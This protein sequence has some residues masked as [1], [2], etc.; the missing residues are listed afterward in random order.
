MRAPYRRDIRQQTD[1]WRLLAG[2]SSLTISRMSTDHL[3]SFCL[4][5]IWMFTILRTAEFE[6]RKLCCATGFPIG[7]A[8]TLVNTSGGYGMI[9]KSLCW[10][11]AEAAGQRS[12]R[13][14]KT[15]PAPGPAMGEYGTQNLSSDQL[16]RTSL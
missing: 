10:P 14:M 8:I 13:R 12:G 5:N 3:S 2:A 11:R 1:F 9:S 4:N 15:S 6:R 7:K 16:F